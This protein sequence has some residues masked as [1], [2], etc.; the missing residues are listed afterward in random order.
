MTESDLCSLHLVDLWLTPAG[1]CHRDEKDADHDLVGCLVWSQ[2]ES[3]AMA[4]CDVG[5]WWCW[6][7]G[8]IVEKGEA[9]KVL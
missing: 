7:R 5:V 1:H 6:V 4:W 3:Y 2:A 8:A 9:I